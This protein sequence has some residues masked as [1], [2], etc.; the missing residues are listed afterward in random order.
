VA[1]VPIRVRGAS[2]P[3]NVGH[4]WVKQRFVDDETRKPGAVFIP[5]RVQDNPGLDVEQYRQ[6]MSHLDEALQAQLLDGNWSAFANMALPRFGDIHLVDDFPLQEMRERLEAMDY[7]FNGTAWS[8]VA[9]DFDGNVVFVDLLYESNKLPDEIAGLVV[10]RRKASW[11]FGHGVWADPSIWH[12]TGTRN[13][14]GRPAVLADEFAE[15]GVP[16]TPANNDPR[17]GLVR[18]RILIEPDPTRRFPLWHPRSGEFGSP[19]LFVVASRCRPLVEQ[20]RSAPLQPIEKADGGEKVDPDWEGRFGHAVAMARYAVMSRP[21]PST[22]PRRNPPDI[23]AD[24]EAY[25]GWARVA[26]VMERGRRLE[27]PDLSRFEPV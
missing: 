8:L 22:P 7:G 11:G 23:Y 3:G 15:N 13:K 16:V 6:T 14:L 27:Q 4:L 18:L 17:A 20:L 5:A 12:R 1:K 25:A 2:N 21:S 19:S 24:P 10:G 26:S 9:T